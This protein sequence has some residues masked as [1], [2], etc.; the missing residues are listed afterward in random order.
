M[1]TDLQIQNEYL[2][3][4]ARDAAAALAKSSGVARGA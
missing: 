4:K 3:K 1:V 2:Q